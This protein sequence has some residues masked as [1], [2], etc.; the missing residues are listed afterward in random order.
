MFWVGGVKREKV[1]V[2]SG[3]V[4]LDTPTP[5]LEREVLSEATEQMATQFY[6]AGSLQMQMFSFGSAQFFVC[7]ASYLNSL[8]H[9]GCH[10]VLM[11]HLT[12]SEP[13]QHCGSTLRADT[14]HTCALSWG[15]LCSLVAFF[16]L[17]FQEYVQKPGGVFVD[18][19]NQVFSSVG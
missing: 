10:D 2:K 15:G 8:I 14:L 11:L 7:C 13:I 17:K 19:T 5:K 18:G 1:I 9:R 4:N 12:S 6:V 3:A 16:Q